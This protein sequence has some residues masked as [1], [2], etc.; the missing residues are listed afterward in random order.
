M[1]GARGGG[2]DLSRHKYC[3]LA[4]PSV[5]DVLKLCV[6]FPTTTT[7]A[8]LVDKDDLV[9]W[10]RLTLRIIS[11]HLSDWFCGELGDPLRLYHLV[12]DGK[13]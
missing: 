7:C 4:S 3:L 5:Y 13:S 11:D 9:L 6:E 8:R 1:W 10:E 12:V 2:G